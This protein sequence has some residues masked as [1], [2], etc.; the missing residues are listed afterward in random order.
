MKLIVVNC[1][2]M[3]IFAQ[4]ETTGCVHLI[5]LEQDTWENRNKKRSCSALESSPIGGLFILH[6]VLKKFQLDTCF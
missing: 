1:F 2:Q 6:K 5:V 3:S 4:A